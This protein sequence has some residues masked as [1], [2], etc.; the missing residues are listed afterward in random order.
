MWWIPVGATV[1]GALVWA[2]FMGRD[3]AQ[4]QQNSSTVPQWFYIAIIV[5]FAIYL[6]RRR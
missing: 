1:V 5:I 4:D 3:T 2:Y 6:L